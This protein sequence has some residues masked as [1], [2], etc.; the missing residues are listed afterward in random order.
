MTLPSNT[1]FEGNTTANFKVRLPE[2]ISLAGQWEVALVEMMYPHSWY[3]V[4]GLELQGPDLETDMFLPSTMHP[5]SF[6]V[7]IYDRLWVQCLIPPNNYSDTQNLIDAMQFGLKYAVEKSKKRLLQESEKIRSF[8]QNKINE[9]H[10]EIRQA[11][12]KMES[13]IVAI[14]EGSVIQKRQK[15]DIDAAGILTA[16]VPGGSLITGTFIDPLLKGKTPTIIN[17]S[18]PGGI[19]TEVVEQ[20]EK[21]EQHKLDQIRKDKE[22][23]KVKEAYE[24][25]FQKLQVEMASHTQQLNDWHAKEELLNSRI[26]GDGLPIKFGYDMLLRR[27]YIEV[28]DTMITEVK[29]NPSLA[30]ML[31]FSDS[32]NPTSF[33]KSRTVATYSP[34]LSGGFY[35]LYVYCTQ[36]ENQIVGNYRVPLLRTVHVEGRH[37]DICETVFP[38]PHY[39]PVLSKEFD[40]IEIDIKDDKNRSVKF[41]FGKT[42]AKLHFRKKRTMLL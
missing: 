37:G 20:L 26:D 41:S 6:L 23:K 18:N 21:I 3:N 8:H 13:L 4:S 35:A 14:D 30:Y 10:G 17:K 38:S 40:A 32:D 27:V 25:T 19:I 22:K 36:V 11:Q 39:I 28:E 5:N 16:I 7:W 29:V 33:T 9:F 12:N 24:E 42:V 1:E 15:R 2:K 34:D 31:G